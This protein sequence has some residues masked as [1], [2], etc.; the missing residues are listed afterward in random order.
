MHNEIN[1]MVERLQNKRLRHHGGTLTLVA[2]EAIG[3]GSQLTQIV[4]NW[5]RFKLSDGWMHKCIPPFNC[6]YVNMTN[7]GPAMQF[8]NCTNM[9]LWQI[10]NRRH[11]ERLFASVSSCQNPFQRF[12]KSVWDLDYREGS[13]RLPSKEALCNRLWKIG[14]LVKNWLVK[15]WLTE[16]TVSSAESCYSLYTS[17][18]DLAKVRSCHQNNS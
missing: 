12:H 2:K 15:N 17:L 8:R 4:G 16:Y 5:F 14:C 3:M 6:T 18:Y 1:C 9:G 11:L 13:F 7:P 10:P